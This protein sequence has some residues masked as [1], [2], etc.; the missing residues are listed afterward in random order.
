MGAPDV[1]E[2]WGASAGGWLTQGLSADPC[3]CSRLSPKNRVNCGF[4]GI[5]SDQCFSASC[6]FDSSI[7]G[8]PWC[9]KPLPKQESE[10][11][12]MEVSARKD[13]G[14]PGISPQDCASRKCCFSNAIHQVPW[15]FFPLSVH[16]NV[17][18]LGKHDS[19]G[20]WELGRG[21]S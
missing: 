5:T 15:C 12:V 11:C 14:Y 3:Q 1:P 19:R 17:R 4:P 18:F 21:R 7:P 20:R 6:C 16:G 2:G 9:F 13:C 8:V 10:E